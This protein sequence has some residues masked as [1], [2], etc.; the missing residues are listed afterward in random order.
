MMKSKM[1]ESIKQVEKM[2]LRKK[3]LLKLNMMKF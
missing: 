2:K 3:V 1:I